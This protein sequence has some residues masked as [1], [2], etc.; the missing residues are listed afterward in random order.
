MVMAEVRSD[1]PP[2]NLDALAG[3]L[4]TFCAYGFA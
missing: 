3:A 2:Q 4:E 1:V